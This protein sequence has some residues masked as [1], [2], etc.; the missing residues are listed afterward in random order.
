MAP[1]R[2]FIVV[3]LRVTFPGPRVEDDLRPKIQCVVYT[4]IVSAT[5]HH[6][7]ESIVLQIPRGDQGAPWS[8]HK[9]RYVLFQ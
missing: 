2:H 3:Q 9:P 8:N 6:R 7:L 4:Y 1:S 5:I